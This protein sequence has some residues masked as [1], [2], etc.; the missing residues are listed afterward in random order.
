VDD[1]LDALA[2][3][4]AGRSGPDVDAVRTA[5]FPAGRG[6]YD[7]DEVDDF[8]DRVV[9]VLLRRIPQRH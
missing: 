3:S 8:L 9:D 4:L 7:E 2:G 5:V 6:G 1:F